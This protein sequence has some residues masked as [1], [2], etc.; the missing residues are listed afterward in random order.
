MSSGPPAWSTACALRRI[1]AGQQVRRIGRRA[2]RTGATGRPV[3]PGRPRPAPS[4]G[5]RRGCR[6]SRVRAT[7]RRDRP[8]PRPRRPARPDWPART[9]VWQTQRCDDVAKPLLLWV[10]E[11]GARR[12]RLTQTTRRPGPQRPGRFGVPAVAP[13]Q[14]PMTARSTPRQPPRPAHTTPTTPTAR[15]RPPPETDPIGLLRARIDALDE[16]II[17]LVSE[18]ARLSR[19]VQISGSPPAASGSSSTASA[20]S[21]TPT[22]PGSATVA[23]RSA[24]RSCAPAAARCSRP[25]RAATPAL[26]SDA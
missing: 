18:R 14:S 9:P 1:E 5:C 20:R 26:R 23:G 11:P 15:R 8:N 24:T 10:P 17:R 16:G 19:R 7:I 22:A 12:R 13:S 3:G 2:A 4:D 25:P 6:S 21:S